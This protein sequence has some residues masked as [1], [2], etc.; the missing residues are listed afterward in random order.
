MPLLDRLEILTSTLGEYRTFELVGALAP[1]AI[2]GYFI[3]KWLVAKLAPRRPVV[4][5]PRYR[6]ESADVVR[7]QRLDELCSAFNRAVVSLNFN[8]DKPLVIRTV[9]QAVALGRKLVRENFLRAQIVT[10]I[11]VL[12]NELTVTREGYLTPQDES[13][14]QAERAAA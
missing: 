11:E 13:P 7:S 4:A 9:P 8:S 14:S 2:G 10:D 3:W 12:A 1:L 6:L 5:P